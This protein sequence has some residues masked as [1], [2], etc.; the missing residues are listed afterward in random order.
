MSATPLACICNA[1]VGTLEDLNMHANLN[2]FYATF[3]AVPVIDFEMM[4]AVLAITNSHEGSYFVNYPKT[5]NTTAYVENLFPLLPKSRMQQVASAYVNYTPGPGSGPAIG[6]VLAI[7]YCPSY[8][9][10]DAFPK[11][12]K[13]A[14][15]GTFAIP[16][17]FHGT[18]SPYYYP[19]YSYTG[20][21][22]PVDNETFIASF[23]SFSRAFTR[24]A[25]A[26]TPDH[27]PTNL[28]ITPEWSTWP[29]G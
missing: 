18:G 12:K 22:P 11:F 21:G 26:M 23:S 28:S 8:Y 7:F 6:E 15:T 17:A 16:D 5:F 9:L 20:E 29:K 13:S 2:G 27:R 25:L 10:L 19:D 1:S 3:V 24:F 4:E 14:C